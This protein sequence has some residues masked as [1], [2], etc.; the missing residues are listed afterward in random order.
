M[1]YKKLKQDSK[2]NKKIQDLENYLEKNNLSIEISGNIIR[3]LMITDT[4]TNRNV[5][6]RQEDN[7][8]CLPRMFDDEFIVSDEN[9]NPIEF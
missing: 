6:C 9:G 4:T 5:T 1:S 3:G 7:N 8:T 2:L